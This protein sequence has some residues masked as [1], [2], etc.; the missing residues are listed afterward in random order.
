MTTVHIWERGRRADCG[1]AAMHCGSTYISW[2]PEISLLSPA[3][4]PPHKVGSPRVPV[5]RFSVDLREEGRLPDHSVTIR[6]LD[7]PRLLA[8]WTD[9]TMGRTSVLRP[10]RAVLPWTAFGW[11]SVR[12]V[13][14]ALKE[15]GADRI[16]ASGA[17]WNYAL[18]YSSDDP[19]WTSQRLREYVKRIARRASRDLEN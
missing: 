1:H 5:L 4:I 6:G 17:Y 18:S 15:A 3:D 14:T 19:V 12:L 10:S 13:A 2:F 8:W 9:V 7:E 16:G 11:N